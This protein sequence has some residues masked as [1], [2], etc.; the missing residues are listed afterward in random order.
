VKYE[1]PVTRFY[2][3]V[4]KR[5]G[6]KAALVVAA[7]KLATVCYSVLVHGRPYFNPWDAQA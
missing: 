5:C 6:R 3:G 7:R 4:A 2:H 1:T